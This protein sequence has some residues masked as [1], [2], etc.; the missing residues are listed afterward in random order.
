MSTEV[1]EMMPYLVKK[2]PNGWTNIPKHGHLELFAD[3]KLGV[4]V[5][6]FR[7]DRREVYVHV[8][9][10]EFMNPIPAIEMVVSLY[11]KFKLGEP[12]FLPDELNWIHSIPVPG[13]V[14]NQEETLLTYQITQSLFWTIHVDYQ[15]HGKI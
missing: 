2:A 14:L 6:A 12:A 1:R 8:F 10:N 11:A 4:P 9:C 7:K 3:R 13:P 15:R 5:L